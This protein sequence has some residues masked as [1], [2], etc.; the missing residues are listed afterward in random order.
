MAL[1]TSVSSRPKASTAAL[2]MFLL[3]FIVATES[4]YY[5]GYPSE[6]LYGSGASVDSGSSHGDFPNIDVA[7]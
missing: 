6:L 2:T 4:A 3:P 1:L 7:M 5:L